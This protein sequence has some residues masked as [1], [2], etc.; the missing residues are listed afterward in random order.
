MTDYIDPADGTVWVVSSG[1][2]SDYRVHCAAPSKK[3]AQEIVDALNGA[4]EWIKYFVERVPVIEKAERVTIYGVEAIITDAGT[5]REESVRDRDEW[6]VDPLYPER[7]RPV[8]VRWVRAPIYN[9]QAGRLEVYGTDRELV[10]TTFSTMK[11]RLVG[12]PELRQRR[13]FTR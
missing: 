4:D 8:T 2:Y 5:V 6:N 13:E 10:G 9:G 12:D 11:A 3:A 7:L 1:S